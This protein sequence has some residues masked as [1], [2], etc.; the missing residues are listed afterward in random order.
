M[1]VFHCRACEQ[2]HEQG[3]RERSERRGEERRG[4]E[5]DEWRGEG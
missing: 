1:F 4:E 3:M 2:I 5:R